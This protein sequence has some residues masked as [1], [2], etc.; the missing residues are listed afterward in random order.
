MTPKLTSPLWLSWELCQCAVGLT[1]GQQTGQYEG[2]RRRPQVKRLLTEEDLHFRPTVEIS[3]CMETAARKAALTPSGKFLGRRGSTMEGFGGMG[4]IIT[5]QKG[6]HVWVDLFIWD[7]RKV[8][9]IS[10]LVH[11]RQL[12][13]SRSTAFSTTSSPSFPLR[14]RP[15]QELHWSQS[16][17]GS[18]WSMVIKYIDQLQS[19]KSK[20]QNKTWLESFLSGTG[21]NTI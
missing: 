15:S 6:M 16:T 19:G 14:R 11:Q 5:W 3:A 12:P 17:W 18:L 7:F 8:V 1:I 13:G 4:K 21:W 10:F 20:F 2:C 9:L